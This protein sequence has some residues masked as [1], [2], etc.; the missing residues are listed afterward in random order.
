MCPGEAQVLNSA[1]AGWVLWAWVQTGRDGRDGGLLGTTCALGPV[2]GLVQFPRTFHS[3]WDL[4]QSRLIIGLQAGP[5]HCHQSTTLS[6][7]VLQCSSAPVLLPCILHGWFP[8]ICHYSTCAIIG[9]E[10]RGNV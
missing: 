3:L 4:G 8:P 7:C 1:S 5:C 6:H 10:F 2:C 9:C